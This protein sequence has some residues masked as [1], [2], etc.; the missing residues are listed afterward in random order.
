[1]FQSVDICILILYQVISSD[2]IEL[3]NRIYFPVLSQSVMSDLL[4]CMF[5]CSMHFYIITIIIIIIICSDL[6]FYFLCLS[7]VTNSLPQHSSLNFRIVAYFLCV[8][9]SVQLFFARSLYIVLVWC[10]LRITF[11]PFSENSLGHS[12]YWYKRIIYC[13]TVSLNFYA[14][15]F[16]F[17]LIFSLFFV[18]LFYLMVLLCLSVSRSYLFCS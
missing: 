4:Q 3:S 12:Y 5:R 15:S 18:L 2:G 14:R 13:S 6:R 7:S 9:P 17:E 16:T 11:N 10:Y 1:V 8:M